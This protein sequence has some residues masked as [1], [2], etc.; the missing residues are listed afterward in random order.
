MNLTAQDVALSLV[1]TCK[2]L[3]E[4]EV[5]SAVDAAIELLHAHGLGKEVRTFPRTVRAVLQKKEGIVFARLVTPDSDRESAQRVTDALA[6]GLDRSVD[7]TQAVDSS[8]LGGALLEVGDERFD[9]SISG[10]LER[11]RSQLASSH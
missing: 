10:S 9:V 8:L 4:G 11:M 6:K 5:V 2:S 7:I 1:E 3:P